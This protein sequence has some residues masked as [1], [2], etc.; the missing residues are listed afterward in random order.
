MVILKPTAVLLITA[1][2]ELNA[3]ILA[4]DK[5]KTV[6]NR[7]KLLL[8]LFVCCLRGWYMPLPAEAL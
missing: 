2:D 5:V 1:S 7:S 3:A 4:V 8:L 6:A